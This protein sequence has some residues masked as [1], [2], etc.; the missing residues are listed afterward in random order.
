MPSPIDV[1]KALSGMDYPASGAV[2]GRAEL[3]THDRI[4]GTGPAQGDAEHLLDRAVGVGDRREVGLGVDLQVLGL[5]A[6][7]ADGIGLVGQHV[8]Q[9]HVLGKAAA[10][11]HGHRT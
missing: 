3:L 1:Q 9:A 4:A 5:E 7:Q 8:C 6:V 2:A 11:C 10:R